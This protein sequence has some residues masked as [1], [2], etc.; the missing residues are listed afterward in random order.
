MMKLLSLRG[1]GCLSGLEVKSQRNSQKR[2]LIGKRERGY[3]VTDQHHWTRRFFKLYL[4]QIMC[5]E[6]LLNNTKFT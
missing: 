4:L 2:T 1:A 6:M 5:I 3:L